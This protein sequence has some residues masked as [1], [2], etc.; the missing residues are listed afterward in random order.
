MKTCSVCGV[1]KPLD[2]FN[3]DAKSPDGLRARCKPCRYA[4]DR[5]NE[6]LRSIRVAEPTTEMTEPTPSSSTSAI[7]EPNHLPSSTNYEAEPNLSPKS[8]PF[9]LV[10]TKKIESREDIYKT[11]L[12]E[13][14]HRHR[15][16]FNS[17]LSEKLRSY[18]A[19]PARRASNML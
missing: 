9:K 8:A 14:V 11:A 10:T 3:R 16:E 7:A 6:R 4:A 2:E 17:I 13:L 18:T 1:P 19:I 15:T 5:M 12:V